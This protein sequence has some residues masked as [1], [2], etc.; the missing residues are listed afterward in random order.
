MIENRSVP[1][2]NV[3]PHI[4]YQD[5][6]RAS[7]WLAKA[8]GFAEHFRY[9][10]PA[11]PSGAQIYLGKVFIMLR[12]VR[13]D[14]KTPA[15]LGYGTQSLSVFV[16]DVDAHFSAPR[17]LARRSSK[18]LTKQFMGNISTRPRISTATIGS[19]RDTRKI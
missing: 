10:D 19:F 2:K 14:A 6:A 18:N 1:T 3:I 8:F 17:Q 4:T 15:Q 7:Q 12:N 13:G 5:V 9:G 16:E 11:E